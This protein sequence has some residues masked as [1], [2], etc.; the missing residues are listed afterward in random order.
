MLYSLTALQLFMRDS[1]L[2]AVH[3]FPVVL[4]SRKIRNFNRYCPMTPP[5]TILLITMK[6]HAAATLGSEAGQCDRGLQSGC[7]VDHRLRSVQ[8]PPLIRFRVAAK[9]QSSAELRFI[10]DWNMDMP[11]STVIIPRRLFVEN[12]MVLNRGIRV[13][14]FP[15]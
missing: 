4:H 13:S 6:L 11:P 8:N 7:T 12:I 3:L 1:F 9:S 5:P 10:F 2:H 14:R 15:A